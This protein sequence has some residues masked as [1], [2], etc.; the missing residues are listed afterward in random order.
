[1][2]E[3]NKQIVKTQRP[4]APGPAGQH[5]HVVTKLPGVNSLG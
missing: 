5:R 4:S 2:E 3:K 1:M